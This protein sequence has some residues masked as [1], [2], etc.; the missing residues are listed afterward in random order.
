MLLFFAL[1]SKQ[2]FQ[3]VP[4]LVSNIQELH[5]I[6]TRLEELKF[7]RPFEFELKNIELALHER[8]YNMVL[9]RYISSISETSR[10]PPSI[11]S[12]F[13]EKANQLDKGLITDLQKHL[14]QVFENINFP[15][16]VAVDFRAVKQQLKTSVLIL[17]CLRTIYKR[18][19]EKSDEQVL[20]IIF[21]LFRQSFDYHFNGEQ[22]TNDMAKPEWFFSQTIQW[23]ANNIEYFE[24]YIQ[25]MVD[26]VS[27]TS[28]FFKGNHVVKVIILHF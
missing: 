24:V 8:D 15:F 13:N 9:T 21:D 1:I 28:L 5:K 10:V 6:K 14:H 17:K 18:N 16:D 27:F 7:A 23:I 4:D 20:D 11:L 12:S 22:R 3:E 19:G 25:K 2:Y 26:G